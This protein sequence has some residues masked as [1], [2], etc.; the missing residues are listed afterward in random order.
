MK[1]FSL[2]GKA[3]TKF[4]LMREP[5][6]QHGVGDVKGEKRA[7]A[8]QAKAK[9]KSG[10]ASRLNSGNGSASKARRTN[11]FSSLT[12]APAS[13]LVHGTARPE[14]WKTKKRRS[15]REFAGARGAEAP[16]KDRNTARRPSIGKAD[17][18]KVPGLEPDRKQI[19]TFFDALFRYATPGSYV[20]LRSFTDDDKVFSIT[21]VRLTEGHALIDK[22]Y[23]EAARAA[24]PE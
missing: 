8:D 15:F 12:G 22:A 4:I 14:K 3:P 19:E 18:G 20:S 11:S 17:A 7:R 2:A 9:S 16:A 6:S 24:T 13:C 5:S 21:P 1:T 23:D 10:D